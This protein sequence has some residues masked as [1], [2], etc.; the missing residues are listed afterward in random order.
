MAEKEKLRLDKFLWAIRIFKTRSLSADACNNA[1]VKSKGINV[2]P[3]KTVAVGD[4]YEIKTEHK[5][6]VIEVV[7]LLHNRVSHEQAITHYID[8]TPEEV[9]DVTQSSAFIFN[10][11]K[12]Q[13]K[14]GRPT[15]KQKRDLDN[16]FN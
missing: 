2:K 6:W 15:K 4:F 11:G 7:S 1:K 5:K 13:S 14:Q 3:S 10:T 9:K 8:H 12:R 16:L